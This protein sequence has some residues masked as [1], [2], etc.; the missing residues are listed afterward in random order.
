MIADFGLGTGDGLI[1]PAL[2]KLAFVSPLDGLYAANG[3]TNFIFGLS[4]C[5]L[6]KHLL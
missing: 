1:R 6:F 5:M 2:P 4:P 3:D